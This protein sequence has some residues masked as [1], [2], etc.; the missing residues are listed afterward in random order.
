M[1]S[2]A[3]L[4]LLFLTFLSQPLSA[5]LLDKPTEPGPFTV[6]SLTFPDLI[7]PS[8]DDRRIPVKVHLPKLTGKWPV[9]VVSHGAGGNW[10]ANYAQ[11]VHLASYGYAVFCVEHVGS[12]TDQMKKSLRW[13]KNVKRMTRNANEVL[14]RPRDISFVLDK[15]EVWNREHPLLRDQLDLDH[16]GMLGHSFGAYTTLA[17]LGVRPALDWLTPTVAPGAGLGPDLSD[18]RVD[19]GVALSPQGPGEPFFLESSYQY[20]KR[21]VL[22][23]T[24]SRDKQQGAKPENRKK[25]FELIPANGSMFLWLENADHIAFSD[26]SGSGRRSL[27][28][29]T[30]SDVQPITRVATLYFFEARLRKNKEAES[31]LSD[32][33]LRPFLQGKVTDLALY[34]K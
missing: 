10:D 14:G 11:A 3:I 29:R 13:L 18:P 12:N 15:A 20:L 9:V 31:R 34:R 4:L 19:V 24:G 1:R 7:D 2:M 23:I 26:A 16:I 25:F 8:R 21:P 5:G 27:Y 30:R 33:G 17:V 6:Q 32:K 22:G 28:S